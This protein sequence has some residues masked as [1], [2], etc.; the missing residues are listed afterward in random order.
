MEER[1]RNL[2]NFAQLSARMTELIESS[3]RRMEERQRRMEE[4]NRRMEDDQRRRDDLMQQ[5]LQSVAVMQAEIVRIDETH[6]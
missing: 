5:I 3:Q 2:E 4:D 6:S 1:I